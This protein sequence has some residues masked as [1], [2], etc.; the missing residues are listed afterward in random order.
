M[1]NFR[2]SICGKC[3]DSIPVDAMQIG[4]GGVSP[5]YRFANGEVHALGSTKLGKRNKAA[6][7]A[8][9]K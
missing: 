2:C 9:E 4:R 5:L 3:F 1:S 6:K 7:P 8:E